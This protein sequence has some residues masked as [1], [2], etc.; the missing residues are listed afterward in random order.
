MGDIG[1]F[2]AG[3]KSLVCLVLCIVVGRFLTDG[4]GRI[5]DDDGYPF[6]LLFDHSF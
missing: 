3:L 1:V 4:I 5:A 6:L 2:D